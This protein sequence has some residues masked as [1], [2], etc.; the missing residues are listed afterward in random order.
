MCKNFMPTLRESLEFIASWI[1]QNTPQ[2]DLKPGLS[3]ENIQRMAKELSFELPLEIYELYMWRNGGSLEML[4][5]PDL[6]YEIDYE[7]IQRFLPLNEAINI[8][9]DWK[10][11]W[12]PLFDTDG[13][14]FWVI[15]TQEQQ[16]TTPIFSNDE[17]EL[18]REPRYQ[19]LTEMMSKIVEGV[20]AS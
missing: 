7:V 6:A 11:G 18:P 2:W 16:K 12:L 13:V 17:F 15:G 3:Y 8:A 9:K 19:S 5:R 10:N 14:I 4:P 1:Q 20:K